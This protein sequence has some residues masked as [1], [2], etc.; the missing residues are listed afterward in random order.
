MGQGPEASGAGRGGAVELGLLPEP[1]SVAELKAVAAWVWVWGL[2]WVPELSWVSV[3]DC[4]LEP[5]GIS[6]PGRAPELS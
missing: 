6:E 4:V 5:G 2:D 1:D 3:T